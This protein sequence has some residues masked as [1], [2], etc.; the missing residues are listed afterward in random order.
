MQNDP[1]F[2]GGGIAPEL[3]QARFRDEEQNRRRENIRKL[4]QETENTVSGASLPAG[5]GKTVEKSSDTEKPPATLEMLPDPELQEL[6]N[7]FLPRVDRR[8]SRTRL[9]EMLVQAGVS[10]ATVLDA[11]PPPEASK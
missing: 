3:A 8:W 5:D 1:Y 10:A 11:P 6:A 4:V 7:R 9:I 2:I